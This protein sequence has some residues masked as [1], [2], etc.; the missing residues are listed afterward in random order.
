V[1]N[2]PTLMAHPALRWN[3]TGTFTRLT[4]VEHLHGYMLRMGAP[5]PEAATFVCKF[6]SAKFANKNRI[7]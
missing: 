6:C 4:A 7:D 2:T 1:A 3:M 5:S